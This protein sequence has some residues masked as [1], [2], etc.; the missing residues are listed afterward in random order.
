MW[1]L[2]CLTPFS[3]WLCSYLSV[4][5]H[6]LKYYFLVE[7]MIGIKIY[8]LFLVVW[9]KR[10]IEDFVLL[11]G[12][13]TFWRVWKTILLS[14]CNSTNPFFTICECLMLRVGLRMMECVQRSKCKDR[15]NLFAKQLSWSQLSV[16]WNKRNVV[17]WGNPFWHLKVDGVYW[18][19]MG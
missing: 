4:G 7:V 12:L 15:M 18:E 14:C 6:N 10:T 19:R 17:S 11:L 16:L 3:S 1:L 13:D 5:L 9:G 2:S 8:E